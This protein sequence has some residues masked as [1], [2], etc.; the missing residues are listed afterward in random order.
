VDRA[1]IYQIGN[2]FFVVLQSLCCRRYK[3][4]R[5]C[6]IR[7]LLLATLRLCIV[8]NVTCL[9]LPILSKGY[10]N[11]NR[12]MWIKSCDSWQNFLSTR[13]QSI[14][15]ICVQN[16]ERSFICSEVMD[17]LPNFNIGSLD[18]DHALFGIICHAMASNLGFNIC[19]KQDVSI[20]NRS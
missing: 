16:L 13:K 12:I 1:R 3:F 14:L 5:K 8:P 15:W 18:P 9:A 2:V 6:I 10:Q 4:W 11:F 19:T 17:E 20:F 7:C